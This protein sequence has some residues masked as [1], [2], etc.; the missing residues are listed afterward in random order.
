MFSL[1]CVKMKPLIELMHPE[2][3]ISFNS[4]EVKF[5][6]LFIIFVSHFNQRRH[7]N[8]NIATNTNDWSYKI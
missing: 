6:F 8:H 2:L 4:I 1:W 7:H 3:T 5:L